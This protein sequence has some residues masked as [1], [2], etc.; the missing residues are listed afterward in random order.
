MISD[1]ARQYRDI[2]FYH[3]LC[4]IHEIRP[5][6]KLYKNPIIKLPSHPASGV[7]KD[8]PYQREEGRTSARAV[9]P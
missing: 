4:W 6:K 1:D 7:Q 8:S 5:Y 9:V 3:A 2:A